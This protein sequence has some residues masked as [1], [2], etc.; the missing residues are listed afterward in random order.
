MIASISRKLENRQPI[1]SLNMF[2]GAHL[3][4]RRSKLVKICGGE[5][6]DVDTQDLRDFQQG[7]FAQEPKPCEFRY[8]HFDLHHTLKSSNENDTGS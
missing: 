1:I 7:L 3:F 6:L 2:I 5:F 4:C 8:F